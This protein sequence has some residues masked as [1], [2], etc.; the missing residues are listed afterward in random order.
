MIWNQISNLPCLGGRKGAAI[1]CE[2]LE[3]NPNAGNSR[4]NNPS[5]GGGDGG[6]PD[7]YSRQRSRT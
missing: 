7:Y 5:Y 2:L 4:Y 6:Y 1:L 3:T